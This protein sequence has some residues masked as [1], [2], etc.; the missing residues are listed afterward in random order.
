MD[1]DDSDVKATFAAG[2]DALYQW[3]LLCCAWHISEALWTAWHVFIALLTLNNT[4]DAIP[5][6]DHP[7]WE[8]AMRGE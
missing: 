1:D 8:A 2:V 7:V 5:H 4:L 6:G 3:L